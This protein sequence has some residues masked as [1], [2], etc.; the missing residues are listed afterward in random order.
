MSGD[1]IILVGEI[2][3]DGSVIIHSPNVP[4]FNVVAPNKKT[5]KNVAIPI[6]EGTLSLNNRVELCLYEWKN[7]LYNDDLISYGKVCGIFEIMKREK[8]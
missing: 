4:L 2:R 3:N 7:H 1:L 6:M 5:W 8:R